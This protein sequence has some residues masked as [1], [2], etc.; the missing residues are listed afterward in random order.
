MLKNQKG[1]GHLA[2]LLAVVLAAVIGFAGWKVASNQER[3]SVNRQTN[4]PAAQN[5]QAAPS[6]L[7]YLKNIGFN[8][9]DYDPATNRAGDMVFTHED[10]NLENAFHKIFADFGTQDPRSPNDPT[11]RNPQPTFILP[12]GT[13]VL[14]MVDGVVTNVE[15]LY[16]GD[17]T[18]MV[19][20][21]QKGTYIYE[22]E[23]IINP[24]VKKGD[25]V[26]AG[27][28]IGEVS[29]HDSKY[30]PGFGILEI[31]ILHPDGYTPQHFCPFQYLDSSIK[32]DIQK[33]ILDVHQAW[34][35]FTGMP[36]LYDDEHSAEPGCFVT[37]P[38]KG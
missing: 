20:A 35:K 25:S 3:K 38:V 26:K 19:A 4:K 28:V 17:S 31:G 2:I 5:K 23:H 21:S 22:T 18:V 30:H 34:E 27:Q 24:L 36:D 6:D 10:N 12:L 16:S 33:Y 9:G 8:F 15:T 37:T 11:K 13:K 1:F 32:A 29:T 7:L 14:A